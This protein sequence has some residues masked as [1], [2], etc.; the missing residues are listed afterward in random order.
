MRRLYVMNYEDKNWKRKGY[1]ILVYICIYPYNY[2]LY[3]LFFGIRVGGRRGALIFGGLFC[4]SISMGLYIG[5]AYNRS[6]TLLY[7]TVPNFK[8]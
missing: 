7:F 2:I 3:I 8:S 1:F 5:V 6:F 4:V